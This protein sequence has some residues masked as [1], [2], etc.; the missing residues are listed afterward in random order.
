MAKLSTRNRN[1]DKYY[2]DGRP[3]PANWEYRFEAAKI[4]GS[5]NQ[6][7][8]AGFKT[9]KDAEIAGTKAMAEYNNAG[10]RIF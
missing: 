2:K 7:S 5:R 8:K 9:K 4:D 1:K 3:K 10:N 6:I